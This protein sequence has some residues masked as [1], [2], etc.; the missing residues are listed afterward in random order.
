MKKIL[1]AI[2]K[3]E[4]GGAQK[5]VKEQ[6]SVCNPNFECYLAT[7]KPGWLTENGNCGNLFVNNLIEKRFSLRYLF[8]LDKYVKD[9]KISII[10]AS[11]ANAGIYSRLLKILNKK[12]K[13]VYVS[14]GWSAIYNGKILTRFYI[15]VE[16]CLSSISDSIL[17]I[18]RY[19]YQTAINTIGISKKKLKWISNSIFPL[20]QTCERHTKG[21]VKLLSVARLSSPKRMDLLISAV[22]NIDVELHII[23]DGVLKRGLEEVSQKNVIFHGEIE[24]FQQF[25]NFDI[26]CLISDSEGLPLSAIEAMS[27]GL[28]LIL[29]KVGGCSELISGNGSLVENN[30]P[31]ITKKIIESLPLLKEQGKKSKILFETAFNLEKNKQEYI[32][33]YSEL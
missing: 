19:D 6:I 9:N 22:E 8:L 4:I 23:G 5:W 17:C 14:H 2:T 11:S 3:S 21:N 20:Y 12:I 15:Q 31:D 33:Y 1:F 13:V 32:S 10:I 7:N 18:S 25:S 30:A 24:N 16:R 26:F 27:C 29:S 28:P